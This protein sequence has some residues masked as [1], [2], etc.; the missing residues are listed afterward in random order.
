MEMPWCLIGV[1]AFILALVV[2]W[3]L[4]A[5][6]AKLSEGVRDDFGD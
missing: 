2:V 4:I 1:C 3:L 5:G 6:A